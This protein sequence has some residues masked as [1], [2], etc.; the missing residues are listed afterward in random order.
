MLVEVQSEALESFVKGLVYKVC[1]S[2]IT[3]I[4]P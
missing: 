3:D 1:C 2:E 4:Y